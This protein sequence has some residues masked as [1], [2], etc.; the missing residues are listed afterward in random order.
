MKT[1]VKARKRH[2]TNSLDLTIPT[3]IVKNEDISAGDIFE[4]NFEKK[5][6]ETILTY[7]RIYKNK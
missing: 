6:K 1:T 2:G 5:D 3:E 7:K 4:L